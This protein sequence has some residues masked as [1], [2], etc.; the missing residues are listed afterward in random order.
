MWN[1]QVSF[2]VFWA[3]CLMFHWH[4]CIYCLMSTFLYFSLCKIY[5]IH[6]CKIDIC[7]LEFEAIESVPLG[8]V[9]QFFIKN[10]HNEYIF[11]LK[12]MILFLLEQNKG[13]FVTTNE[14]I[15]EFNSSLFDTWRIFLKSLSSIQ[16]TKIF[17][18]FECFVG[19]KFFNSGLTSAFNAGSLM[20]CDV[21]IFANLCQ[22]FW[23]NLHVLNLCS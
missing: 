8:Q 5:V 14:S 6:S 10:N 12:G 13:V 21:T 20:F 2:W 18:S 19:L 17:I 1:N 11:I 7:N 3:M 22:Y 15:E 23:M 9:N 4:V 16:L